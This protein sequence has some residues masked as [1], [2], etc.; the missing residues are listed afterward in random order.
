MCVAVQVDQARGA[1]AV[2]EAIAREKQT[3]IANLEVQLAET[4][5]AK[6]QAAAESYTTGLELEQAKQYVTQVPK[7]AH[8]LQSV[9]TPFPLFSVVLTHV[10][11]ERLWSGG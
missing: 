5:E 8:P 9:M 3:T 4:A 2:A 11:C 10:L 1:K 7:P 6:R